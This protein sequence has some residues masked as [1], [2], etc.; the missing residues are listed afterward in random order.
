MS[1]V[2]RLLCLLLPFSTALAQVYV[3][4]ELEPWQDWVLDGH[5][6][7]DCPFYFDRAAE[8]R[9]DFLC[10]W[11]GELSLEV[12]ERGG[13]FSQRL[14]VAGPDAWL[15]LPGDAS[16]WPERVT[17]NGELAT[18]I[19]RNGAPGVLVEPGDYLVDGRFAWGERPARL[20]LPTTVGLVALS[21]D[22]QRVTR[23]KS[24]PTKK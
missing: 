10:V 20:R 24:K 12:G 16:H 18:V 19:E 17:L 5:E 14:S 21:L 6:Y 1:T 22:G 4:D 23:T 13:R 3:P 2:L 15:P 7:R 11:P 9:G 8:Q